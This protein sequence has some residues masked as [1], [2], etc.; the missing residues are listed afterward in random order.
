MNSVTY[1]DIVSILDEK[2]PSSISHKIALMVF[3]SQHRDLIK[4]V[5]LFERVMDKVWIHPM[6][7]DCDFEQAN[8]YWYECNCCRRHQ[9]NKGRINSDG[10]VNSITKSCVYDPNHKY[11]GP[12]QNQGR[13][14]EC[15]CPCRHESRWYV[16][17]HLDQKYPNHNIRFS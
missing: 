6:T 10:T 3:K 2:I 7:R 9:I 11:W 13:F 5:E 1:N 12:G 16:R 17:K 14:G 15:L 4:Q 8:K